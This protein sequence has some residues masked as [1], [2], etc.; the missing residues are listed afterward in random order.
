[1]SIKL[2]QIPILKEESEITFIKNKPMTKITESQDGLIENKFPMLSY[3][4]IRFK[5][6]N[7]TG[8]SWLNSQDEP[9]IEYVIWLENYILDCQK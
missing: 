3:P 9:D 8:N 4:E 5:Y 1:M 6:H 2:K 7:E